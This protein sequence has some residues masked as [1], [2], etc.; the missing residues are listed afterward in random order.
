MVLSATVS[1]RNV[2][3]EKST[4]ASQPKRPTNDQTHQPDLI[5]V[6]VARKLNRVAVRHYLKVSGQELR[7]LG[8]A[9]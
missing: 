2:C 7:L 6:Q 4:R 1:A 3:V 5:S 8:S 9:Q